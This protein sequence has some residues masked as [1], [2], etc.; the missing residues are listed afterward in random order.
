MKI[1]SSFIAQFISVALIMLSCHQKSF[2]YIVRH[3]EKS[4][5]P[6]GDPF[7]SK[8]GKQR[9][10]SLR[11]KLQKRNIRNIFSTRFNRTRETATDLSDEIGV[12]IYPYDTDTLQNFIKK[13]M[14]LKKNIL[15]IGHSN[16]VITML[17][18]FHLAHNVKQIPDDRYGDVF[19]ITR[20]K[21]KIVKL[22]E[23]FYGRPPTQTTGT[24]MKMK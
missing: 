18:S 15:I 6:A 22:K 17:D 11:N 16:T 3:A 8:E 14:H 1:K 20:K 19:I 4:T 13:V 24:E 2:I 21:G 9:A 23:T 7:L 5:E 10:V 12:S